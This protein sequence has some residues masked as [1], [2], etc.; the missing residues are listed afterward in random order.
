MA[1]TARARPITRADLHRLVDQL[2]D[3]AIAS[4]ARYLR[5]R[6]GTSLDLDAVLADAPLD[7]E[8]LTDDDR[9]AIARTRRAIAAGTLVDDEVVDR[10]LGR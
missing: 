9:A 6:A 3:A 5:R 1:T 8:P 4:V 2:P 7:D 10:I